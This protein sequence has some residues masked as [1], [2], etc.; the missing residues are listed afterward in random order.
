MTDI[1]HTYNN[2]H[3]HSGKVAKGFSSKASAV[4]QT[5]GAI[6]PA[7]RRTLSAL[8][9]AG[10]LFTAVFA[11]S[12]PAWAATSRIKDIVDIE[13][14]RDNQLV[15]YGIVVGLNGSG[16]SLG[17]SP[18]TEQSLIAMLERL[19]VNVRGQNLNT[20]NC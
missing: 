20:G 12:L 5:S 19:G 10:A 3:T 8:V 1:V 9:V 11:S 6:R 2:K 13:G 18:F 7:I 16:D 4:R 17:N 15:G 14:V